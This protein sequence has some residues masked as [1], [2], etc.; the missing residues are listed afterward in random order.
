[1]LVAVLRDGINADSPSPLPEAVNTVAKRGTNAE[2]NPV[3]HLSSLSA[4]RSP[5]G[6]HAR[7]RLRRDATAVRE[8]LDAP[9]LHD[10]AIT[11]LPNPVSNELGRISFDARPCF[12]F[13]FFVREGLP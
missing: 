7:L 6:T 5:D 10:K 4:V 13:R 11:S 2:G 8:R 9:V 1:M 12:F 3:S